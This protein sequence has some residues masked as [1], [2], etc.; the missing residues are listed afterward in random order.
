[1][2]EQREACAKAWKLATEQAFDGR[3]VGIGMTVIAAAYDNS[4]AV[5]PLPARCIGFDGDLPVWEIGQVPCK[6]TVLE[7]VRRPEDL[8]VG[9]WC[10]TPRV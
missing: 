4:G 8:D 1:M 10:W 3:R 2:N 5:S 9:K 6:P 7:F